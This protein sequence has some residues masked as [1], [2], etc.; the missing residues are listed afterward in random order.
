MKKNSILISIIIPVYNVE[1]YVFECLKSVLEQINDNVEVIIID[2]GSTDDSLKICKQTVSEF[3][4]HIHIYS[5]NNRG[6]SAT[7]NRGVNLAN[8]KYIM[9]V[10]SDD[11]GQ[12]RYC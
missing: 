12:L 3:N 1:E 7:R 8:G 5:Q 9:F 2:D 4:G 11:L 6:L 10:D